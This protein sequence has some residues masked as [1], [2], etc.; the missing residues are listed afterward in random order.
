MLISKEELAKRCGVTQH[1][2]RSYLARAEFQKCVTQHKYLLNME[3][4]EIEHLQELIRNR[5][6]SKR[7]KYETI[8]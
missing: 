8:E 2:L 5:I 6:G 4:E 3:I 1:C 7:N